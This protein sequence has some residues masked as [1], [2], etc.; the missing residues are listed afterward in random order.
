MNGFRDYINFFVAPPLCVVTNSGAQSIVNAGSG[1]A[2]TFDTEAVDTD[3]MHS[4]GTNT[5]RLTAVTPGYYVVTGHVVF[6]SNATGERQAW[7]LING[8]GSRIG[9]GTTLAM[10]GASHVTAVIASTTL[11]LN[12]G[13]YVEMFAYQ[14]SG[15]ALNTDV[16]TGSPRLSALWVHS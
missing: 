10:T 8:T 11:F 14:S 3:G 9:F 15:G 5:S 7:L 6:A 2:V 12:V 13:D 16:T 1:S 4:T